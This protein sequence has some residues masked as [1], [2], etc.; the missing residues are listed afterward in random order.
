MEKK[1]IKIFVASSA[2]VSDER[3]KCILILNQI[4]KSHTHLDLE[5]IEWEYD[6]THGSHPSFKSIQKAINPLLEQCQLCVFIFHT[7]IG[8][9][10]REEFELTHQLQK[11]IIPFFKEG[12]AP[13][14]KEEITKLSELIDFREG[15][16]ETVLYKNYTDLNQFELLLKD[17]LHLYLSQEFPVKANYENKSLPPEVSALVK[18]ITEKQEEIDQLKGSMQLPDETTQQQLSLLEQQIQ[19]LQVELNKSKEFQE[20]QAKD[21]KDLEQRLAPQ[22]EKDNLKQQAYTA[23]QENNFDEAKELLKE[24]AKE[25]I[26]ETA[27]TFY[28]LG[29]VSKL[30]LLYKEALEY[31][32]LAVRINPEGFDMNMETGKMNLYLGFYNRSIIHFE[33]ALEISKNNVFFKK[34]LPIINNNLG[35]SYNQ[36]GE[37][38]TAI[39]FYK[40]ALVIF[41]KEHYEYKNE[42]FT[43]YNNLGAAYFEKGKYD[44]SIELYNQSIVIQE[45]DKELAT[46]YSNL[47]AA[48]WAK[49]DNDKA[50]EFCKKAIEIENKNF[51]KYNID[52]GTRYSILGLAY[53]NKGEFKKAINYFKIALKIDKKNFGEQHPKVAIRYNNMGVSY[54]CLEDYK[55]AIKY[56]E[57]SLSIHTKFFPPNHQKIITAEE[58]LAQAQQNLK[59]QNP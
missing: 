14:T 55:K 54:Q 5:A 31:F 21:K 13:K 33:K 12:F 44:K 40:K 27:T 7:K 8:K 11:K 48:Y 2:E 30:Q 1:N 22:L 50:I 32:E 56:F 36:I 49:D 25:S 41:K 29:K 17:D 46:V 15:L 4:N 52:K 59:D 10:T 47:G 53:N 58:N 23:L 51:D 39:D 28:E 3:E 26:S 34:Y 6:L 42:I 57:L 43:I 20:Q 18:I 16:N 19:E 45:N 35:L 9:Y 37:H 24:S 38:D